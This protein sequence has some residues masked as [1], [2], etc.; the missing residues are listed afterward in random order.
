LIVGTKELAGAK[1]NFSSVVEGFIKVD[2]ERCEP[3]SVGVRTAP[4]A[5]VE[6]SEATPTYGY[7]DGVINVGAFRCAACF[8]EAEVSRGI[9]KAKFDVRMP[10]NG[11]DDHPA[12]ACATVY[13]LPLS[14]EESEA[15]VRMLRSC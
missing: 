6:A 2:R 9:V 8:G 11:A 14:K 10:E 4:I 12:E 13:D 15:S 1:F 3:V 7:G 5:A